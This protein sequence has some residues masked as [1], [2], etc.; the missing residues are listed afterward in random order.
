M[1]AV[2]V[3]SMA[4]VIALSVFNGLEEFITNQFSAIDPE[5][6]ISPVSGKKFVYTD[7]L[8]RVLDQVE[9]IAYVTPVIEDNAY[10]KYR[11]SEIVVKLLGVEPTFFRQNELNQ[12]F[13][14]GTEK[15]NRDSIY[16][17]ILGYGVYAS[18]SVA[19]DDEFTPLQLY[20][21]RDLKPGQLNPMRA[22]NRQV[23][24]PG[25][26]FTIEK[27]YDANYMI[28]DIDIANKLMG[29]GNARSNLQIKTTDGA[30]VR[31][32]QKAIRQV[33]GSSFKVETKEEQHVSLLRAIKIEKIFVYLT[34]SFILLIS[35][36]NI[37]F[38]LT[39]LAIEKKKD[40]SVLFALG[41]TIRQIR[42]IF[43]YEGAIIAFSGAAAGLTIGLLFCYLQEQFGLI[44]LGMDSAVITAYPI[45][46]QVVDIAATAAVILLITI[47]SSYRPAVLASRMSSVQSL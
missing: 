41:Y 29:Y 39:M 22:V 6:K 20:Y 13:I 42:S 34:L 47:V 27:Q 11:D 2:A 24:L 17:A 37:F 19:F 40:I 46:V 25:A 23:V 35:S 16:L 33:L 44:S 36:F 45:S 12:Y 14:V 7:S 8:S 30:S 43:L 28:V 32:V 9:G 26:I 38:S 18:L 31:E 1:I 5:L 21:P 15:L 4:L 3:G 10:V